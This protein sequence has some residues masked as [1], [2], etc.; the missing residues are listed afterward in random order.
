[1]GE[2]ICPGVAESALET[3]KSRKGLAMLTVN[4]IASTVS[5]ARTREIQRIEVKKNC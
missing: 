4:D 2:K 1:M 3:I 5:D